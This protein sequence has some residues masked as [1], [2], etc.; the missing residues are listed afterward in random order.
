MPQVTNLV[1]RTCPVGTWTGPDPVYSKILPASTAFFSTFGKPSQLAIAFDIC[2]F[3]IIFSQVL[4]R[5]PSGPKWLKLYVAVAFFLV[6]GVVE[7]SD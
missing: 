6:A 3:S 7:K 5:T 1:D 4:K 2:K